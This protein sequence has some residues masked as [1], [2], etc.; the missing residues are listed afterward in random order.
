M[1]QLVGD[2]IP[3]V[4]FNPASPEVQR[5]PYPYY[6]WLL[7]NDRVHRG[8]M[9]IW[10]VSRYDD[11]RAIM[12][13]DRFRRAGIRDFWA[14]LMGAGPLGE[15]VRHTVLFQDE[16]D[17]SRLRG[18]VSH[19]FAARAARSMQPVIERIVDDLMRPL[20]ATGRLD[21]IN[22][23]AYPLALRV[24]SD[25]IGLPAGD[26]DRIRAWSLAIGPTLDLVAGPEEIAR[27]QQ[28]MA[29]LAAY[30][31]ELV[32]GHGHATGNGHA[33]DNGPDGG[34][35]HAGDDGPD[36][37]SP[38]GGLLATM[39]AARDGQIS[40]EEITAMVLTLIFAGHETVTNQIGNGVLALI[41]HPDQLA[42]LRAR[43]ELLH[44]A[45][46]EILRY[47]SSVQS[48]SRQLA[49]DV[50]FGD[51]TMRRG[52]FVVVLAGAANRDPDQFTDPDR[53]DITRAEAQPLSF[54]SGMRFC[55][56]AILA[57]LE[58]R[59]AFSRLAL[60]PDLR[61]AV[62]DAELVYHRSTMFRG[63]LSLPVTFTPH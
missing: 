14:Q 13:D 59:A 12:N 4:G 60:L 24:I 3:V 28:A 25:V 49:E 15:I 38:G 32:A 23:L 43:P 55:L 33:S 46:E 53:F 61:L 51:Q 50:E 57:R 1:T 41:R 35:G 6:H 7:R 56:G 19:P 9:G 11:V 31:D 63:L 10:F 5:D 22:D 42:L 27:G 8:A 48:N 45:V 44:D 47:D 29:E 16:P 34:N 54:G 52:E 37:D 58:L 30:V 62:A 21:V 18:L 2:P 17:H 36:G 26:R 20:L 39:V 40:T